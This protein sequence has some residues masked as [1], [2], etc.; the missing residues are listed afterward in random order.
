MNA[1]ATDA[2]EATMTEIIDLLNRYAWCL[3]KTQADKMREVFAEDGAAQVKVAGN[4]A[5]EQW[6]GRDRVVRGLVEL[7]ESHPRW[8]SQQLTTPLF[9][10][11]SDTHATVRTYLS[12]FA[13]NCGRTPQIAATGEYRAE[14]SKANDGWVIDRLELVLDCDIAA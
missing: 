5:T 8:S 6:H 11:I 14:V 2:C 4:V 10:A 13:S 12:L 9:S 3:D 1:M 7:S